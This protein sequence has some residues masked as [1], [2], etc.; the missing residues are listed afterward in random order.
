M[1]FSA[2]GGGSGTSCPP[3]PQSRDPASL[4]CGGYAWCGGHRGAVWQSRD[5]QN[6]KQPTKALFVE[7]GK[8]RPRKG[9][10]LSKVFRETGLSLEPSWGASWGSLSPKG[11]PGPNLAAEDGDA[12]REGV[13]WH[14]ESG[15]MALGASCLGC[16]PLWA[17]DPGLPSLSS[18]R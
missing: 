13:T 6:R 17:P 5:S 7:L 14:P 15:A 2:L 1:T 16:L 8:P 9:R 18:E 11:K 12:G 4:Q 3:S 10:G